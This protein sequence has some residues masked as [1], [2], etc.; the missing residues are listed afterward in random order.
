[1]TLKCAESSLIAT[2]TTFEDNLNYS[3]QLNNLVQEVDLSAYGYVPTAERIQMFDFT[4]PALYD[5]YRFMV[6]YPK[7]Q[8]RLWGPVRPFQLPVWIVFLISILA[9]IF[10]LSWLMKFTTRRNQNFRNLTDR[11]SIYVCSTI[12]GQAEYF[13][14][15]KLSL[16]ILM[17]I[18]LLM[19]LILVNSY[20]GN[21][22]SY[23]T[24]SKL[25][26]IVNSYEDMADSSDSTLTV[27]YSSILTGRILVNLRQCF[28]CSFTLHQF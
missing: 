25:N 15:K 26:P 27:S 2:V 28:L 20:T 24:V 8:S 7:E 12:L 16:R 13:N 23:L 22:I 4:I 19:T 9:A 18:W 14:H 6:Q 11:N 21:L 3:S 1:L 5:Q 17:A 10:W